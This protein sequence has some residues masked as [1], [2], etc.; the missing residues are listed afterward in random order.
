MGSKSFLDYL[1][2][3]KQLSQIYFLTNL[4]NCSAPEWPDNKH[5]G[6][7]AKI[8]KLGTEN[9]PIF[10]CV[11]K[12]YLGASSTLESVKRSQALIE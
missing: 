6:F 8:E 10:F 7:L 5:L 9:Q 11:N 12:T 3:V 4:T 1:A 2:L